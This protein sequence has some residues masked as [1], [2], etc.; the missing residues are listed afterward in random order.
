MRGA[1]KIRADFQEKTKEIELKLATVTGTIDIL[2][3]KGVPGAFNI[4]GTYSSSTIYNSHDVVAFNGGSWVAKRDNPG[5]IPGDGWQLLAS[6]GSRGVKG[7]RGPTGL[8]ATPL[9]WIGAGLNFRNGVTLETRLSDGTMGA[10]V[11]LFKTIS[12]D[13]EDFTLKFVGCDDSVLRISLLP[14]F[15]AYHRQTTG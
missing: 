7:E 12:V 13:P 6:Q 14:L 5:P 2:K 8:A 9:K 1:D 10:P 3:G 15:E 4:K 11:Q